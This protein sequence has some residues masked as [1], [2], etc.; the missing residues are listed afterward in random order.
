MYVYFA[1]SSDWDSQKAV[2]DNFSGWTHANPRGRRMRSKDRPKTRCKHF[3]RTRTPIISLLFVGGTTTSPTHCH[4]WLYG[5][6]C[7]HCLYTLVLL[8]WTHAVHFLASLFIRT[9]T[10]LF[11]RCFLV[12]VTYLLLYLWLPTCIS[13]VETVLRPLRVCRGSLWYIR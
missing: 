12:V 8:I 13:T 11:A 7:S 2:N 1:N 3:R 6:C 5:R 10:D 4:H 9:H